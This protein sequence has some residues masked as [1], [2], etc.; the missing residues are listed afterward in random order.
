MAA[1]SS[2]CAAFIFAIG[3]WRRDA[4][5]YWAALSFRLRNGRTG[6]KICVFR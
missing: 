5:G 1:H 2:E 6:I 3:N 4:A